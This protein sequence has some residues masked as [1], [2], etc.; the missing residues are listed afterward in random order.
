MQEEADRDTI[1][2]EALKLFPQSPEQKRLG[3]A[4]ALDEHR[5]NSAGHQTALILHAL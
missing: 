4:R 2:D 5:L 3:L 1:I